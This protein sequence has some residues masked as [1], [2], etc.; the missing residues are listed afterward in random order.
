MIGLGYPGGRRTRRA[1]WALAALTAASPTLGQDSA[2]PALEARLAAPLDRAA[3]LPP[4]SYVM[5]GPS[6]EPA[7]EHMPVI[8]QADMTRAASAPNAR[9]TVVAGAELTQ[10]AVA[11]LRVVGASGS[12]AFEASGSAT[13]GPMRLTRDFL[14][15]PGEY[16]VTAAIGLRGS[17]GSL[18]ASVER[19][20]FVVPDLWNGPLA[21]S[22]LVLG[23]AA[24]AV[25]PDEGGRAFVFGPTALRP[26]SSVRFTQQGALRVALRIF[27]WKGERGEQPDLKVE[28]LF[29]Q[30]RPRRLAFFNKTRPQE[31]RAGSLAD[32][33]EAASRMVTAGMTIPLVSFPFGDFEVRA[34]VTD[35]RSGATAERQARF[36]VSP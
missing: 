14:L 17:G 20:R 13:P 4:G 8:L 27:N 30:Q 32:A 10:P 2:G 16:D 11:K 31:L 33:F 28:Y 19:T 29:Y 12:G 5:R 6:F 9:V 34:R 23:D 3:T 24:A 36:T 21:V 22:P 26:V 7:A 18:S 15:P 25:R 35:K 1:V